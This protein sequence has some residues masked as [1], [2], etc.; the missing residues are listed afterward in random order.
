[1]KAAIETNLFDKQTTLN[2]YSIEKKSDNLTIK[3]FIS[4]NVELSEIKGQNLDVKKLALSAS[5]YKRN[6]ELNSYQ[7]SIISID[8]KQKKDPD[9]AVTLDENA[10]KKQAVKDD[11][12]TN[13]Y[14]IN[15]NDFEKLVNDSKN[16]DEILK[17][18]K[19]IATNSIFKQQSVS[20]EISIIQH[21]KDWIINTAQ[22]QIMS[23]KIISDK[24]LNEIANN[25]KQ[26]TLNPIPRIELNRVKPK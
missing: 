14:I 3:N 1:M 5:L 11:L 13:R 12:M 8:T 16:L 7:N 23:P 9:K 6:P 17:K 21:H 4:R 19:P 22:I 26:P 18:Y 15:Q 10:S 20:G 24:Q 25:L 2:P